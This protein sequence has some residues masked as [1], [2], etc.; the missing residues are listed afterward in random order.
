MDVKCFVRHTLLPRSKTTDGVERGSVHR[1]EFYC[2]Y[3][4]T[5]VNQPAQVS[6]VQLR[7]PHL[8][9]A[10][11]AT[12]QGRPFCPRFPLC[13]VSVRFIQTYIYTYMYTCAFVCLIPSPC[14]TQSPNA[15]PPT[16]V[17]LFSGSMLLFLFCLLNYFVHESP[18]RH[19]IVEFAFP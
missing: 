18:H 14:F 19:E 9:P 13:S 10:S 2:V 8:H 12:A 4:V 15:P 17:R 11:C 6:R 16:A 1:D 3:G 5:L 7:K